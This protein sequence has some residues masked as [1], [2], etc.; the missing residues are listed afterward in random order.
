[1]NDVYLKYNEEL[2]K[3]RE[4]VLDQLIQRLDLQ[5]ITGQFVEQT[6]SDERTTCDR[7]K[8]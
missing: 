5:T 2:C 7:C 4:Y 6:R 3:V 1:M 8:E